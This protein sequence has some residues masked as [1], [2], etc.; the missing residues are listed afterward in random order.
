MAASSARTTSG[1]TVDTPSL[2]KPTS[3]RA[4]VSREVNR[5]PMIEFPS[6][7]PISRKKLFVLVAV[8]SMEAGRAFWMIRTLSWRNMPM[9]S[10]R[11]NM[12][13]PIHHAGAVGGTRPRT[14]MPVAPS[15]EPRIG[16][17]L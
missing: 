5:T 9:P 12:P 15:S 13:A 14:A 6:E 11:T 16:R 10:W 1:V 7:T 4:A 2:S 17:A 3:A 8:P